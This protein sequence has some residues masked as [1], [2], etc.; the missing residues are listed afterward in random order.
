L[1]L[2]LDELLEMV[3]SGVVS[4][5]QTRAAGNTCALYRAQQAALNQPQNPQLQLWGAHVNFKENDLPSW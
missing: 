2:V 5:V 1:R 4:F 3:D